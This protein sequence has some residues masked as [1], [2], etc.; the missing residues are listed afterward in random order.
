MGPQPGQVRLLCRLVDVRHQ[1][2]AH[3]APG[4]SARHEKLVDV[5]RRLQVGKPRDA[6]IQ[7]GHEGLVGAQALGPLRGVV[8]RR[9]PGLQ[10]RGAVVRAGELVDGGMEDGAQGAFIAEME[11]V[12]VQ[13]AY[14][15]GISNGV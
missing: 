9:C 15:A 3:A 7:L 6:A 4:V 14:V 12:D 5:A 2:P 1:R 10:L 11:G 13:R 8:L